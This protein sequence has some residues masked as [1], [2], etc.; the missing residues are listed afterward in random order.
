MAGAKKG[1]QLVIK[2]LL[3]SYDLAEDQVAGMFEKFTLGHGRA[4]RQVEASAAKKK[5][6]PKARPAAHPAHDAGG[7]RVRFSAAFAAARAV[8]Q[9]IAFYGSILTRAQQAE[10]IRLGLKRRSRTRSRSRKSGRTSD[11]GGLSPISLA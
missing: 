11:A 9:N 6:E 3:D 2:E 10:F 5:R 1:G 8:N 7:D 4:A